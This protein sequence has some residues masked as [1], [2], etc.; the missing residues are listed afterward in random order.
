MTS[1]KPDW[2]R[3]P[4]REWRPGTLDRARLHDAGA[5]LAARPGFSERARTF[6]GF[7]LQTQATYPALRAVFRNSL[8]YL[9]L[10][11]GLVLHHRR[12]PADP[13]S[14]ITPGRILAFFQQ[15][16]RGPLEGGASQ[17]KAM[18]AHARLNGLLRPLAGAGDARYRPLEPTP[19]LQEI[20]QQWLA[21]F[22][23]ACEGDPDLLL[24][25]PVECIV[26]E[27]GLVGEVFSHRLA[28]VSEDRYTLLESFGHALDWVLRH[29]HGYRVF[30][31]M[32]AG[33]RWLP[34]TT[35]QVPFSTSELATR[36]GVSRGTVRNLLADA[37]AQGW[38]AA[39]APARGWQLSADAAHAT[40][41]WIAMELVW[42]HGLACAAF[43]DCRAAVGPATLNAP[44]IATGP[45]AHAGPRPAPTA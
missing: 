32:T 13:L 2:L 12:D 4:P 41:R 30:L 18:L 43:A 35:V 14:G 23:L 22:L 19:L 38:F 9:L 37:A 21:G 40:L 27:P 3:D 15:H 31:T 34:D 36:A 26:G 24:P 16:G 25:A 44:V 20:M 42:M 6:A 45:S 8:R 11:N 10:V 5:R 17:V 29:D 7:W 39:S 33:M 1:W 28:A